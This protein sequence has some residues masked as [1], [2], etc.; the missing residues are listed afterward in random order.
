MTTI[1]LM[2]GN[3]IVVKLDESDVQFVISYNAGENQKAIIHAGTPDSEGRSGVVYCKDFSMSPDDEPVP[4]EEVP[5]VHFGR[6]TPTVPPR[7][8]VG[9]C[10]TTVTPPET[11]T[12]RWGDVSCTACLKHRPW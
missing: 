8:L 10:G 12:S 2:S 5:V 4:K 6:Y 3:V 1:T 7:P 11:V 9:R